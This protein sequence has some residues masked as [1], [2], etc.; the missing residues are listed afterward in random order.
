[1][2]AIAKVEQ[3]MGDVPVANTPAIA[4]DYPEE[5]NST[6][7]KYLGMHHHQMTIGCLN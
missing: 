4:N 1:M 5:D 6:R 7:L 3:A 2:K